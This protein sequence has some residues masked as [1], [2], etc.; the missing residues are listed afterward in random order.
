ME[1]IHE[2][3]SDIAKMNLVLPEFQRE[4][5][6]TR[7]QAKQ[8]FVSLFREYPTGSLLFWKTEN[9]PDIKNSAIDPDKIGKKQ[10]ILDGQQRLTTL[11]MLTQDA[12][13]PYYKETDIQT[14]PRNLYFN[15]DDGSFR[16]YQAKRM[17]SNPTW[18]SVVECFAN[19]DSI[20]V[21]EIASEITRDAGNPMEVANHLNKNLTRLRNIVNQQYPVQVVP[22]S[23]EIDD[24]IDVFDRVNRMGTTLTDAELALA[25]ITGKWP[26]ARR[27]MKA[28]MGE[29]K[30][31]RFAFDLTFMVRALT[32]VV[33]GRALFET[34]HST[35]RAEL[36]QGWKD[37]NLILD[38]LVSILPGQ[39]S[40]H[41]TDDLNT[42]NV[43]V[44]VIVYLAQEG[45]KQ[46]ESDQ[47][48]RR[49]L[50]W[51]YAASMWARYSGQTTN[52]LD[53]DLSIIQREENPWPPLIDAIID[54]R[55]RIEV[56]ASD[57]EGRSISHPLYRM[58]Y[59]VIKHNGAVDWSNGSPLDQP[60]GD[61]YKIHKHHIF[62]SSLLYGEGGYSS[63][64]HLHRKLV[65]EIANRA[66]LTGTSNI[67]LGNEEPASYLPRIE[68]NYPGAIEKQFVPTNPELWHLERYED[69]LQERRW[70]L[71]KA[72]NERMDELLSLGA[73]EEEMSSLST[74]EL[75]QL[76]ESAALEFK[77]T[78]RWDV[79]RDQVNKDLESV[80]AKSV[81]GFMNA[82][83]G[84]LLIGVDD[85]GE[86]LGLERDLKTLGRGDVD[87][88]HQKLVQVLNNH[89]GSAFLQHVRVSFDE[90]DDKLVC[91]VDVKKS[92]QPVY[93]QGGKEQ[94]FY[95]RT[96]N[97]TRP[98]DMQGA[99]NY[100]DMHW[101]V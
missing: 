66:F 83:G 35:P 12:I 50:R 44:P 92:P 36:E 1:T 101:E 73:A 69:F 4:Y 27:A 54:Q 60:H 33:E 46:F 64:N 100:I 10:V 63:E 47:K 26:E 81:A 18:Q 43:L 42:T 95:V 56:K 90:V 61:A 22:A 17:D 55:G 51:L 89:L 87:G 40:V 91:M 9:P 37:L 98:F 71:A 23:A 59:V 24:A 75:I 13:P 19:E 84:T 80:I 39:A 97:T 79:Y 34:I 49:C 76:E 6:W 57:F 29:L 30:G 68:E 93:V 5:V 62:P 94:A 78:L 16:Y 3:L 86:V 8:L 99:H 96:G 25:H 21:F 72:I 74:S 45:H 15:L 70:L 67:S 65:N 58:A 88:F 85:E 52:R 7:E 31:Q 77:S 14:D 53:H 82:E 32:G 48:L 28:K 41:S 2:L 11:Y 38:Y 20:N